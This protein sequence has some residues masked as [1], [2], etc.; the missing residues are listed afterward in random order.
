MEAAGLARLGRCPSQ[1]ERSEPGLGDLSK[2]IALKINLWHHRL[3]STTLKCLIETTAIGLQML[4]YNQQSPDKG[5]GERGRP[6]RQQV[7]RGA[8]LYI[9]PLKKE[10]FP[11]QQMKKGN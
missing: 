9:P 11:Q 1:Y 8:S 2:P 10:K 6:P 5:V 4:R 7:G 3:Q